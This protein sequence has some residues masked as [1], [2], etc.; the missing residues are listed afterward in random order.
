MCFSIPNISKQK[1]DYKGRMPY[2]SYQKDDF[3]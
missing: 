3:I 2:H 1:S